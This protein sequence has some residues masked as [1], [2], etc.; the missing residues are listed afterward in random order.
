VTLAELIAGVS[1]EVEALRGWLFK[2]P[3]VSTRVTMAEATRY[4]E[5]QFDASLS[6]EEQAIRISA[7]R[8]AGLADTSGD[9]R[10]EMIR[11][12]ASGLDGYYDV[13]SRALSLLERAGRPEFAERVLLAHE[14][15]HALDD[16]LIGL[17]GLMPDAAATSDEAAV[18]QA[19]MEGSAFTV[20]LQ[21]QARLVSSGRVTMAEL[22]KYAAQESDR[23]QA[24]GDLGRGLNQFLA[25]YI[26]GAAFLA[27][28]DLVALGTMADNREVGRNLL[29]AARHVP[30]ST[31][32]II[33]PSKY[34]DPAEADEPIVVDDESAERWLRAAGQ[35][36]RFKDT[37]GE[38]W[39]AVLTEPRDFPKDLGKLMSST[40]WTN[41]GAIG[42]GGDRF[43]LVRQTAGGGDSPVDRGVWITV[44]DTPKEAAEF[45][46][47]LGLG[48]VPDGY[49]TESVGRQVVVVLL[50]F[51]AAARRPLVAALGRSS[52]KFT[53]NGAPW[54]A[55]AI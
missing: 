46:R 29:A 35:T 52:L 47:A 23:L 1:R 43:F 20:S 9:Y 15:T 12:I 3:V 5:Q 27:R 13:T 28:N 53:R 11:V 19:L 49:A 24:L 33:H 51:D 31:E 38:L 44:W 32:Q 6:L 36:V 25:A 7:M 10:A 8:V 39:T 41:P 54:T 22:L 16:Q 18:R 50:G 40:A 4:I 55:P 26:C 21:Y 37:L 42:W 48:R 2:T 30:R 17:A 14:L 45:T 34:W